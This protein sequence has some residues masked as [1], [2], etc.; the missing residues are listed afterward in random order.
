MLVFLKN[1]ENVKMKELEIK[2]SKKYH[3]FNMHIRINI[4]VNWAVQILL[5]YLFAINVAGGLFGPL[6]AVF[7]VESII[8]ASLSTVGFALGLAALAKSIVQIPLA[9]FLDKHLGEKDDFYAL[10]VGAAISVAYPLLD[11][12]KSVVLPPFTPLPKN[13]AAKS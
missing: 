13:P 4:T 8:G 10:I 1:S 2:L 7:V 11:G 9:R 6:Y 3:Y 5:L 12:T